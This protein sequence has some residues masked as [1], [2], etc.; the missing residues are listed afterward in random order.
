MD[1]KPIKTEKD[2][3]A[4]LEQID[5]LLDA[6]IEP[7]T[8][9]GDRFEVLSILVEA[10]EKENYPIPLP[11]P[12]EA[13]QY[14]LES[15]GLSNADLEQFIG[16][17]ARVW[18]ILNR[19]RSLSLNM[20]RRLNAGLSIPLEIL[21]QPY[22]LSDSSV[23]LEIQTFLVSGV[24]EFSEEIWKPADMRQAMLHFYKIR[25]ETTRVYNINADFQRLIEKPIDLDIA[26]T[27]HEKATL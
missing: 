15:R 24:L 1:I 25:D 6:G 13:I 23:E 5:S 14:Y 7:D 11:D 20:M 9:E 4:A 19:R 26:E 21:I 3:E 27:V 12:I 10:Y 2:Y 16:S 18:E 17:R 22:D 8:P